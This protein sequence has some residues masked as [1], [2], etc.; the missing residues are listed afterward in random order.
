MM[1]LSR[2]EIVKMMHFQSKS[3]SAAELLLSSYTSEI[4]SMVIESPLSV[5]SA[6]I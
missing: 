6:C 4:H 2:L 5:F 1:K 3:L